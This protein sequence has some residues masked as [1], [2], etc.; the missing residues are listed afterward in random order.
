MPESKYAKNL[1]KKPLR[2][3]GI[4]PYPVKGKQT[5]TMTYMSNGLVPGSNVYI[6]FGWIWKVPEP[7]PQILEHSHDYD[8]IVLHLGTDPDNPEELGS[9]VEFVVGGEKLVIDKTSALF[10]PKGLEHGPLTWKR[11]DRPHILMTMI[12]GAGTLEQAKPGGY[13]GKKK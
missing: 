4:R 8:E 9:E 12:I 2:E 1:V 7:N 10:V 3:A 11:V 5:P 6:E 13:S